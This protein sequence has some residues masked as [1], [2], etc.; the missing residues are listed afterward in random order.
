MLGNAYF[1]VSQDTAA[2]QRLGW[3]SSR[4]AS[5]QI[6]GLGRLLMRTVDKVAEHRNQARSID[7][8][9]PR[10]FQMRQRVPARAKEL[11]FH[12][13]RHGSGRLQ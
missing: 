9:S 1:S 4:A 10:S 11:T 7:A 3:T 13:T 12:G 6:D 2:V 5:E 8:E